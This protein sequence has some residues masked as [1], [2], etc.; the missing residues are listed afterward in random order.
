MGSAASRTAAPADPAAVLRE[1]ALRAGSAGFAALTRSVSLGEVNLFFS[2]LPGVDVDNFVDR[3][4]KAGG[5]TVA[6]CSEEHATTATALSGVAAGALNTRW[7]SVAAAVEWFVARQLL[8]TLLH[9]PSEA[10]A[11]SLLQRVAAHPLVRVYADSPVEDL[12]VALP[13]V[14]DVR[15]DEAMLTVLQSAAE[16]AWHVLATDC[17]LPCSL[18][19]YLRL[20]DD[21]W[22]AALAAH[23]VHSHLGDDTI[24]RWRRWRAKMDDLYWRNAFTHSHHTL[25]V[26]VHNG[27]LADDL[28]V[29]DV[30]AIVARRVAFLSASGLWKPDAALANALMTPEY[31]EGRQATA[32]T[33]MTLRSIA[34]PT[35]PLAARPAPVGTELD[36]GAGRRPASG[37]A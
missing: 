2:P 4:A 3:F 11:R 22:E 9:L 16:T 32:A 20:S 15:A 10:H 19:I 27:V 29:A 23:R 7:T 33:A 35:S 26:D 21:M 24:A 8:H 5:L 28:V 12:Y 17:H 34:E 25:I 13:V 14:L 30:A 6:R 31:A 1:S 18:W 36:F 37:R